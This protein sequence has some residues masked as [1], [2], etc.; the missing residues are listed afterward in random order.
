M[1]KGRCKEPDCDRQSHAR[2]QCKMHYFRWYRSKGKHLDLTPELLPDGTE[3][4]HKS[5]YTMEIRRGHPMANRQGYVM[6]HRLRMAEHIG[7]PLK[8]GENVHHINGDRTDNRLENLELWV[9][10]QPAGQR[11][12][13][14]VGW[15]RDVLERYGDLVD[16]GKL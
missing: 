9:S 10:T 1:T 15:A 6:Q 7:R 14:L 13:D 8:P 16:S 5:G 3:Y 11:P 12:S 4:T 2:G